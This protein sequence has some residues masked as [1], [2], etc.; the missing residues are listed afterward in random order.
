M[1]GSDWWLKPTNEPEA[2]IWYLKNIF[3]S[4]KRDN[5]SQP[6]NKDKREK[7]KCMYTKERKNAQDNRYCP[8]VYDAL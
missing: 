3:L 1:Y 5:C 8:A 2:Y 6:Q 4:I 7:W